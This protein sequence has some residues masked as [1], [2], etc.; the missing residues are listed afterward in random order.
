M[1]WYYQEIGRYLILFQRYS[2][3]KKEDKDEQQNG[4]TW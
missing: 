3:L 1:L 4:N 2:T